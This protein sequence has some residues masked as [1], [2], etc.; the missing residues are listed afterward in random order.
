MLAIEA[1]R[2]EYQENAN[3]E[4]LILSDGSSVTMIYVVGRCAVSL[5]PKSFDEIQVYT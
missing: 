1:Q 3:G 4:R 2:R 5:Y